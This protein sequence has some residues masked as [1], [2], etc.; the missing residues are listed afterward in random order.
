MLDSPVQAA[1]SQVAHGAQL[2]SCTAWRQGVV[3]QA[4]Q[5]LKQTPEG[6]CWGPLDSQE[7]TDFSL[8]AARKPHLPL[9]GPGDVVLLLRLIWIRRRRACFCFFKTW[10]LSVALDILEI[11]L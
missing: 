2:T 10:F 9:S 1:P 4:V 6:S 11:S 7:H 8:L 3:V 5:T